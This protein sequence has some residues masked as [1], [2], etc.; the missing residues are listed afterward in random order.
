MSG[1]NYKSQ[2]GTVEKAIIIWV[3]NEQMS[4]FCTYLYASV[5]VNISLG[6]IDKQASMQLHNW[7]V[8]VAMC[9]FVLFMCV[10]L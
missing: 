1:S 4:F 10:L 5:P 3:D 2:T 8:C 7:I 9:V 6:S